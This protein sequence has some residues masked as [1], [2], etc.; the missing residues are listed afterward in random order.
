MAGDKMMP[1]PNAV[2]QEVRARAGDKCEGLYKR[3]KFGAERI[4][5]CPCNGRFPLVFAH[6][7]HRDA[8]SRDTTNNILQLCKYG[9]DL[10]DERITRRKF[11]ELMKEGEAG[12]KAR[13]KYHEVH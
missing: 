9:H 11:D 4:G 7:K 12:E 5:D 1:I 13:A 6:I 8:A 2:C 10:F 3:T